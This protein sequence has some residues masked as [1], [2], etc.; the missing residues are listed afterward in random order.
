[1]PPR[2]QLDSGFF[3][4][5]DQSL[6]LSHRYRK[7]SWPI[8]DKKL[9]NLVSN[10]SFFSSKTGIRFSVARIATRQGGFFAIP[11]LSSV[12]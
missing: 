6:L 9:V 5:L 7:S 10:I 11:A 12:Q 3:L 2:E 8:P 1:V 4:S